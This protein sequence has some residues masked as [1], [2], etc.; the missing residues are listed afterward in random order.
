[1]N[2]TLNKKKIVKAEKKKNVLNQICLKF[3][4]VNIMIVEKAVKHC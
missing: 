3:L 4:T 1:M 2:D